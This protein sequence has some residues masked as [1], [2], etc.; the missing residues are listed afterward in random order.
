MNIRYFQSGDIWW[1][2]GGI[3]LTPY[4]PVFEQVK[5]FHRGL[6]N[7]C[8]AH[9]QPYDEYKQ[10]CDEY[11]TL[12]HRKEMRG[13]GGIFFD[14]LKANESGTMTRESLHSFVISLGKSF[15]SLYE[16]FFQNSGLPYTPAQREY[17]LWRRSRYVEFNL[18]WDRGTKFGIESEGRA[19]SI[20]MSLPTVAK[21]HYDMYPTEGTAEGIVNRFYLHP[22]DW[23]NL[24]PE[25]VPQVTN[26]ANDFERFAAPSPSS[27]LAIFSQFAVVAVGGFVIGAISGAYVL[28]KVI[29][30]AA[31]AKPGELGR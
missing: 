11:F 21:W 1:F 29:R 25:D 14:Q 24:K 17:Q 3:D 30:L 16:P 15:T 31:K 26:T 22:Q 10:I 28:I 6:F 19:E 4:Y 5:D 12:K 20:L 9:N 13:V 2:G 27:P 7:V 18:L 8:K 23:I